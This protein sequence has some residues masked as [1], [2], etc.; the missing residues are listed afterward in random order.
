MRVSIAL[1]I[2]NLN[3]PGWT[4]NF[5]SSYN[6]WQSGQGPKSIGWLEVAWPISS[7]NLP[8]Q[9]LPLHTS[10]LSCCAAAAGP[11][12]PLSLQSKLN[13]NLLRKFKFKFTGKLNPNMSSF[14]ML[15]QISKSEFKKAEILNLKPF[16]ST[17]TVGLCQSYDLGLAASLTWSCRPGVTVFLVEVLFLKPCR[18]TCTG[19]QV[20]IPAQRRRQRRA[21]A[22]HLISDWLQAWLGVR[23]AE[24][25]LESGLQSGND[26]LRLSR[27]PGPAKDTT[28][29]S[30]AR[31]Q[32]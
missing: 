25:D 14:N 28:T 32:D 17:C 9:Y 12:L 16:C 11:Q 19:S 6:W 31:H 15:S 2:V 22:S 3:L 30:N 26:C 13:L 24:L 27:Q 23:L 1:T 20:R 4:R 5:K 18:C 10:S 29:S 7:L 21:R 8:G